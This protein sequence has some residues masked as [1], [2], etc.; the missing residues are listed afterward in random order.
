MY[1]CIGN[2]LWAMISYIGCYHV[3]HFPPFGSL[4]HEL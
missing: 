1:I 4:S 3:L 2:R